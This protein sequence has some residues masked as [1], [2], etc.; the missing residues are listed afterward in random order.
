MQTYAW[1][2]IIGNS[3][4][5]P[6]PSFFKKNLDP[7]KTTEI[8]FRKYFNTHSIKLHSRG[9]M[10]I[11]AISYVKT[12]TGKNIVRSIWDCAFRNLFIKGNHLSAIFYVIIIQYSSHHMPILFRLRRTLSVTK[13][14]NDLNLVPLNSHSKI[15]KSIDKI[16]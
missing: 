11:S 15:F 16:L 4:L 14:C 6:P 13:L 3:F 1:R 8:H 10:S 7:R 12:L 5:P 9:S 2:G